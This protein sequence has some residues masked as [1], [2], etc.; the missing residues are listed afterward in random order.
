M[1]E[2]TAS[3]GAIVAPVATGLFYHDVLATLT[4]GGVPFVVVGGVA[5][6]LQGVPRFTADLDVAVALDGAILARAA[7][8]LEGI[9]LRCRL[10]VSRAELADAAKVRGWVDERNLR[11]ITFADAQQPLREVDVVVASPVPFADLERTAERMTAGGLSFRVA[12]VE[13][14]IAMKTGTGRAQDESDVEALRRI[15]GA[16]RG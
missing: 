2:P 1:S 6:N 12:S 15:L 7:E 14:L 8:L 13:Q 10:P 11:A 16:S 9:G 5:V 4:E 3:A